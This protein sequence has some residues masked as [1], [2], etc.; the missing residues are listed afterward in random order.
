MVEWVV[1]LSNWEV[2]HLKHRIPEAIQI[3]KA[4]LQNYFNNH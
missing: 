2:G 1:R 3:S 4:K